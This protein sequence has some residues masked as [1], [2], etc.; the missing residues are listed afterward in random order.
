MLQADDAPNKQRW[1]G[2][3]QDLNEYGDNDAT[4]PTPGGS[5]YPRGPPSPP[6]KS[7]YLLPPSP[8]LRRMSSPVTQTLP[9][10]SKSTGGSLFNR[11]RKTLTRQRESLDY[12]SFTTFQQPLHNCPVSPEN[13]VSVCVCMCVCASVCVCVR[14]CACVL[15]SVGCHCVGGGWVGKGVTSI[16][17]YCLPH[18]HE[19]SSDL[20]LVSIYTFNL[21]L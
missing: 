4:T 18:T 13:K 19:H 16:Y 12:S 20:A 9:S 6:Q 11:I 2:F 10:S 21:H 15:A 17:L 8:T 3:I 14:V 5:K 1:V 7:R